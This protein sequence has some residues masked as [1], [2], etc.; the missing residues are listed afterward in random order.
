M[1][2][3]LVMVGVSKDVRIVWVASDVRVFRVLSRILTIPTAVW[4]RIAFDFKFFYVLECF[5][6]FPII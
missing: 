2:A 6:L 4:V 1:N 5:S 3:V